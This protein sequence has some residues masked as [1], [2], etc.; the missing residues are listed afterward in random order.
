MSKLDDFLSKLAARVP[1]RALLLAI[2]LLPSLLAILLP[3]LRSGASIFDFLPRS[4]DEIIYWRE[5]KT[6][7][8]HGFGGG[9]YSTDEY[10]AAFSASP[11]GSHGPAF[12]MLYGSIGKLVGW[13]GNTVI[14]LHLL[15]VPVA[16][17]LALRL[18]KPQPRQQLL[19]LLLLL[20][21]WPLQLYI[22]TNMQEVLHMCMALV[23]AGLVWRYMQH[24]QRSDAIWIALLLALLISFRIVWA[25]GFFP[26]VY[27]VY[28][29]RPLEALGLALIAAAAASLAGILLVRFMYSPYPWFS[30]QV[31][32]LLLSNWRAGLRELV[33]HL[34]H[35]LSLFFKPGSLLLTVLLRYQLFALLLG[36]VLWLMAQ[37]RAGNRLR[38]GGSLFHV[39]NVGS[40]A[41]FVLLFYDILDTRDYRMFIPPLLLS[42][43]LLV[44][45]NKLYLAGLVIA[46]NLLAV[47]PF[48]QYHQ[49]NFSYDQQILQE[50]EQRIDPALFFDADADRWCNTIAVSKYGDAQLIGVGLTAVP[51]GF[52]I[53]TILDWSEF[54]ERPLRSQYVWVDSEYEQP[55]YG[56]PV[57]RLDLQLLAESQHGDLYLNPH[58]PCD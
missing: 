20:T 22:P 11:F 26:L 27:L 55:N 34:F 37:W 41:L 28:E 19:L 30:G 54:I 39:A 23:L 48:L 8:E 18:L 31:L 57:R 6:F 40:V 49:P 45:Q 47:G 4:S 17:A 58:A 21:W 44:M 32:D 43:V 2:V 56:S 7:V 3:A 10:P 9:Q 25:F 29:E 12:A 42:C 53:T 46:S 16:I 1:P 15:M 52:G 33:A 50:I 24:R 5:I 36:A 35:N 13:Q 51:A 14:Y 38:L